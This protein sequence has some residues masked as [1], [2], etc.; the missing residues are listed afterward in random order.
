MGR[1]YDRA[2]DQGRKALQLDP[3]CYTCRTLV[4]LSEVQKGQFREAIQEIEPVKFP[5]AAP[6]DVATT[7]S[8]L[9]LA[10]ETT[11]ARSLEKSLQVQMKQRYSLSVRSRNRLHRTG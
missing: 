9:A 10:G 3:S 1:Q 7:V 11:R 2:I 8:I 4:A 6:V 5:E